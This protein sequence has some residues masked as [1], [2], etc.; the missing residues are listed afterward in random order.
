MKPAIFVVS[1]RKNVRSPDRTPECFFISLKYQATAIIIIAIRII[2]EV[3]VQVIM[4]EKSR[5]M[6]ARAVRISSF[7]GDFRASF[8][9]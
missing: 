3:N 6:R 9:F 4:A 7:E 1:G 8:C 5:I 2:Q